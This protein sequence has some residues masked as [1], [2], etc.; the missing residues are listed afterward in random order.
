MDWMHGKCLHNK[1]LRRITLPFRT[2]CALIPPPVFPTRSTGKYNFESISGFTQHPN[3]SSTMTIE[4]SVNIE[5]TARELIK[6]LEKVS[7]FQEQWQQ[8]SI[9]KQMIIRYYRFMQLKASHPTNLLLVP[10]LD[11]EIVWQTHLLR[12]EIYQANDIEDC[13]KEQAFQDTCQF[14]EQRFGEQ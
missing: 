8:S 9:L 4:L 12:P 6:L 13:L 1:R 11:I 3:S 14:Y 7:K 5:D 10:T 2:S